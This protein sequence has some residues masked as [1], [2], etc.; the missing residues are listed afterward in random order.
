MI[1]PEA[2]GKMEA[3]QACAHV[4]NLSRKAWARREHSPLIVPH[5][6]PSATPACARKPQNQRAGDRTASPPHHPDSGT[7]PTSPLLGLV[8]YFLSQGRMFLQGREQTASVRRAGQHSR[9]GGGGGCFWGPLRRALLRF[10]S[11]GR[12]QESS[13]LLRQRKWR[14]FLE[15]SFQSVFRAFITVTYKQHKLAK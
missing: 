15:T 12:S 8:P 6:W 5:E 3:A 14:T 10:T 2:Q 4:R 9:G 13:A 7:T 11:A 1:T